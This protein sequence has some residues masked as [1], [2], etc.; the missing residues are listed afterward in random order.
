H[1]VA[2]TTP[3]VLSAAYDGATWTTTVRVRH[4]ALSALNVLATSLGG[5]IPFTGTV[6][7]N[8]PAPA[9]D[10][11]VTLT[12]SNPAAVSLPATVTVPEGK[13]SMYFSGAT[14][15]VPVTTP[16]T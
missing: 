4:R 1:A 6:S 2:A 3:A 16:V 13:E 7:L 14:H 15:P 5:G 8:A 11:V 12:S 9:G 10:A